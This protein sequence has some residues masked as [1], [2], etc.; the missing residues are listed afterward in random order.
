MKR[1]DGFTLIELMITI[2]VG[3][4]VTAAAV[5]VMVLGLRI[6]YRSTQIASQQNTTRI[7]LTVMERV[8][9]EEEIQ[10]V[11]GQIGNNTAW[12]VLNKDGTAVLTYGDST[13]SVNGVALVGGIPESTATMTD[14]LLT[15][16]IKMG[17]DGP[18]Y[19]SS[20]YC[21]M[22]TSA[23]VEGNAIQ[24]AYSERNYEE[25]LSF[26]VESRENP[27]AVTEFLSVLASQYGSRGQIL[28]ETGEPTGEYF[29]EWYIGGYA[30][31]PG[32][33]A[34]TPW[35]GCYL[36]W[37]M[38]QCTGLAETPR[39]ANVDTMWAEFVTNGN[40]T[41]SRP[42]VGD[43]IFFDWDVDETYDPAHVGAV[44]AVCDDWVYTIEGNS[45]GRVAV[46][47]YELEDPC[48]LGYGQLK[49]K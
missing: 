37:A 22:L 6:N 45:G 25:V 4:I 46:C 16:T 15:I 28:S 44:L 20:V 38:A 30:D 2:V 14:D 5:T 3:S 23:P 31:N 40:W 29:S 13:I 36:S 24:T 11:D 35:C 21:R 41:P 8:A 12:Q 42:E 33:D 7:L 18:E 49:W 19:K 1:N 10:K 34:D 39:F 17:E 26:A 9:S 27:E 43:I 48:I 47:R 32:W